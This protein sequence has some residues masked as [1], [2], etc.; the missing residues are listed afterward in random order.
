MTAL[1]LHEGLGGVAVLHQAGLQQAHLVEAA[2]QHG[3]GVAGVHGLPDPLG[4]A[5]LLGRDRVVRR[6]VGL[7]VQHQHQHSIVLGKA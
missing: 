3:H 4:D 5:E 6:H 2:G 7:R 1:T